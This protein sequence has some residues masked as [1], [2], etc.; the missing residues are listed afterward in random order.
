MAM[1]IEKYRFIDK[2]VSSLIYHFPALLLCKSGKRSKI[3]NSSLFLFSNKMLIIRA[4]SNQMIVGKANRED[5]DQAVWSGFTL[6]V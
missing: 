5:P 4:R 2:L 1:I 6:F 3:L